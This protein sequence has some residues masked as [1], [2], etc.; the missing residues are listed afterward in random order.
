[1]NSLVTYSVSEEAQVTEDGF[2]YRQLTYS[3]NGI[4]TEDDIY[5][6]YGDSDAQKEQ[7]KSLNFAGNMYLAACD[8][9]SPEGTEKLS[10]S[11]I[12]PKLAVYTNLVGGNDTLI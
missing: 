12:Y 9:T 3:V 5:A 2:T 8:D 1:M 4:F 7:L 10:S 11:N 6:A